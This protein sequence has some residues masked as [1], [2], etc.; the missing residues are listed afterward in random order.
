MEGKSSRPKVGLRK[1][2]KIHLAV[3]ADT[4]E[5]I[6]EMTTDSDVGLRKLTKAL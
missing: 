5:M 4:Q 6:A 3:D 2:V 1:W